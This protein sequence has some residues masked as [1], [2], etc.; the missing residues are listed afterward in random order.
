ME[1]NNNEMIATMMTIDEAKKAI[2][3]MTED[4][5]KTDRPIEIICSFRKKTDRERLIDAY[6]RTAKL[7]KI[8]MSLGYIKRLVKDMDTEMAIAKKKTAA[9]S[10]D[11]SDNNGGND[12][13]KGKNDKGYTLAGNDLGCADIKDL[14]LYSGR[15]QITVKD[16]IV[17]EPNS[18]KEL[19]ICP[20]AVLITG[21]YIDPDTKNVMVKISYY[22]A[23]K[24]ENVIV[25]RDVIANGRK[26]TDALAIKG[27]AINEVNAKQ[28]SDFLT[29]TEHWNID[30]IP[31][32]RAV[33]V[34]GW[35]D[36]DCTTFVPYH[37]N[38]TFVGDDDTLKLFNSIQ[39]HG[40]FEKWKNCVRMLRAASVE[41]RIVIASSFASVLLE[42]LGQNPFFLSIWGGADTG[43]TVLL[44]LS[45][46]VY[47]DPANYLL[48]FNSTKNAIEAKIAFLRSNPACVDEQM[49]AVTNGSKDM[50]GLVYDVCEGESRGRAN[51]DGSARRTYQ[52]RNT[53]IVTGEQPLISDS[54]NDGAKNRVIEI[55]I[56][57]PVLPHDQLTALHFC[58][59]ENYGFAGKAFV[60]AVIAKKDTLKERFAEYTTEFR[61]LGVDSKQ[62]LI[63]A[64]IL[65]ADRLSYGFFDD[66]Q[67]L[68]TK[69]LLPYLRRSDDAS[70]AENIVADIYGTIAANINRFDVPE[71]CR[72]VT[73]WGTI[74]DGYYCILKPVFKQLARD[75]GFNTQVV[76]TFLADNNLTCTT[77]KQK[78][79]V[80][81]IN[82]VSTRTIAFK[83]DPP[84]LRG[85]T[86]S[87]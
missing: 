54:A 79:L 25:S 39:V 21:R 55:R 33:T 78:D 26:L 53:V 37:D 8:D 66:E 48:T 35:A 38:V 12:D 23:G 22:V 11:T 44:R 83:I 47:A 81:E 2:G 1:N 46:S 29:K 72:N 42:P 45:A 41:G 87:A 19:T 10:N 31:I 17:W 27:V 64:I 70:M 80:V 59:M 63:G 82:G 61:K 51:K 77:G 85:D 9:N 40:D 43:K 56:K 75:M 28:L 30:G 60:K 68:S 16:G 3:N 57:K 20:N 65:L 74:R 58:A 6:L 50:E 5:L 13:Q 14:T 18:D 49:T 67:V 76:K 86:K 32:G 24:W 71:D 69:D 52:F 73:S 15:Y 36:K 4:E 84:F 62:A 34:L 7:D